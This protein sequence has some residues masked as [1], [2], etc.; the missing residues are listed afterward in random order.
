MVSGAIGVGKTTL[1]EGMVNYIFGL[2]W[3]D[4]FWFKIAFDEDGLTKLITSYIMYIILHHL[5]SYTMYLQ[6]ES[7]TLTI[8]DNHWF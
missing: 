6:G 2:K 1:I 5:T 7:L 4:D 3:G 8:I